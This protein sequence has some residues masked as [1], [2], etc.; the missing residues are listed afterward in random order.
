MPDCIPGAQIFNDE[1]SEWHRQGTQYLNQGAAIYD[2]ISSRFDSVLTLID[3]DTFGRDEEQLAV[4]H[5]PEQEQGQEPEWTARGLELPRTT[6]S[7]ARPDR[8]C[9]GLGKAISKTDVFTKWKLY[10]NSRVPGHLPPVKL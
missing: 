9:D 1:V 6:T 3:S 8:A 10:A 2:L 5:L 4:L 7:N